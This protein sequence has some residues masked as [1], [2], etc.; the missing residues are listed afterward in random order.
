MA[1]GESLESGDAHRH[2]MDGRPQPVSYR[3]LAIVATFRCCGRDSWQ[4]SERATASVT[5]FIHFHHRTV[6][7][8]HEA[9]RAA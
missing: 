5:T 9:I 1:P 4:A 3:R 6:N 2:L 8:D 7:G